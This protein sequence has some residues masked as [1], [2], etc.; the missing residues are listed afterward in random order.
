MISTRRRSHKL[1]IVALVAALGA[2]SP[3]GAAVTNEQVQQAIERGI[4]SVR[5]AQ[6]ADGHWQAY[7]SYKAG[8]TALALLA[9]INAGV[10]VNDAAVAKGLRALVASPNDMTYVVSLKCQALAAADPDGKVY[11]KQLQEAADWLVKSQLD[12][13]MWTYSPGRRAGVGRGDNSNTQF[14]LLGLHEAAKAGATVPEKTWRLSRIHFT[15]TQ[16]ADGGWTYFFMQGQNAAHQRSYGSM[17]AAGLA[18]LYIC[19]QQL[20]VGGPKKLL[21]GAWPSCGRYQQN[22]ALAKGHQWLADRFSVKENPGRGTGWLH[23]YLYAL[24]RV[25]MISGQQ[26]FGR[27]DWYRE[28]AE[29]L[30]EKQGRD[31]SWA[32]MA[33]VDTCFALLFLAKGN[34]P[35]IIQKV[36]WDGAWNRNIHDVEN[37]TN[38]LDGKLGQRTTWQSV[39]LDAKLTDLRRSPILYITGH[40][41]PKLTAA[42]KTKIQA[43]VDAGGT[44]LAEACCGSEDFRT[45]FAELAKQLWPEY[46]LRPL[47]ESHGVFGSYYTLSDTYGLQGVDIGCRTAVFFSPN[48]LSV[49]WEMQ[50]LE[51]DGKKW[52]EMAFQLGTN[53][54]AYATGREKLATKLDVVELPAAERDPNRVGEIPR[55]AVRIARLYHSGDYQA[56]ERALLRLAEML[57]T[58]AAV[59][60]VAKQRHLKATDE[61]IYEYPVVF[62]TG[63]HKFE[64]SKEEVDALRKYLQRG[65]TL[66]A[67]ACCGREQ[68]DESFRQLMR[69]LFPDQKFEPL[70]HDHPIF[71]GQ[72]GRQIGRLQYRQFLQDEL[73]AK[74]VA[75]FTGTNRPKIES[76]V[77]GGRAAVLYSAIDYSCALEG[78]RPYACLG[79]I[80]QDGRKLALNL[81]LYAISY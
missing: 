17:T 79:Y 30:V 36:M 81:V 60:V 65:G 24:E 32:G 56:D 53:I 69:Q 44:L 70:A 75:D 29:F 58:D 52:S 61:A 72:V 59:D 49:L 62:M 2:G 28:G 35:V 14:A 13:G 11:A 4:A 15:N 68:F 40:E 31:G 80:D 73:K 39:S 26:T 55:G 12:N 51:Q 46:P 16:L 7:G 27:H 6:G 48:A 1:W 45:G 71:N 8:S 18:S 50:D 10:P 21:Q 76:V 19:G 43:F 38:F 63:H 34:R 23:Y 3:L 66:I 54:A 77:L 74:N 33:S 78:D 47:P 42:Q 67:D 20:H 41:F 22:L 5:N 9:M 25:G 64:M 57:R 37:L